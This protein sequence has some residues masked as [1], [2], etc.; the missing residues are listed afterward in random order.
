MTTYKTKDTANNDEIDLIELIRH[1]WNGRWLIVKV[2]VAFMILGL[3]IAFTTTEQFRAEARLLP[4]INDTQGG[5]SA[6]LKQFGGLGG[7]NLPM[8]EGSDAIRP[9]LY[10]DLLQT[11]PFFV[12]L[13]EQNVSIQSKSEIEQITIFT[14]VDQNMAGSFWNIVRRYTISL[15]GTLI[16]M[17]KSTSNED[18]RMSIIEDIPKITPR[19]FEAMKTLRSRVRASIDQRTGIITVS[20]EL[21]DRRVA[22][23]T[24]QFAV[25][26]LTEY[27]TRYRIQKAQQDLEFTQERYKERRQEFHN[28]QL[29]LARFR[30]SNRNIISAAAQTEEQRLQDQYN[31]AFNVYNGLAQQLEQARIKVQEETPVITLLEPVSI[32]VER[33]KPK[34]GFLLIMLTLLGVITAL[35]SIFVRN[36]WNMYV[37][38]NLNTE[39]KA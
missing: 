18:Q 2:T 15:P 26:Y 1:I 28:A 22:A 9:D 33:S 3:V 13:M 37:I 12:L 30:D 14:Y 24:A 7:L 21:P 39:G 31:L 20:A 29:A 11:T 34:R 19:Q 38:P 23:Q 35:A 36:A 27:I 32:P 25:E 6:L 17:V 4:E 10:P 5:A 8:G 16:K